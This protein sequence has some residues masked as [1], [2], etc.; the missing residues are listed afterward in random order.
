MLRPSITIV[1]TT[2]NRKENLHRALSS[3]KIQTAKPQVIVIDD[4]STDGTS[5]MVKKSFPDVLLHRDE[6]SK[7]YIVQRNLA[8]YLL[9]TQYLISIDD[10]AM[11]SSSSVVEQV[12]SE[13]SIPN[14]GAVAIPFIDVCQDPTVVHQV[15]LSSKGDFATSSYIG[16]AHALRRDVF[17]HLGGYREQLFHQGEESDYCL[18]MLES[19]YVVKLG[20]SDVIQ[21][22]ESPRRDFRRMDIY[23]RRNNILFGWH[24]VPTSLLPFYLLGT[25]ANGLLHGIRVGRVAVMMQGLAK[26]YRDIFS[27]C[28]HRSPV[29]LHTYRLYRDLVKRGPLTMDVV[30]QRLPKLAQA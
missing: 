23:G 13:F 29:S 25:T 9:Q 19:G 5:V 4:G 24:N 11:F 12:L 8:A 22:F 27:E 14:V 26:G 6:K 2:R 7:G 20:R 10:D 21:H 18:R 15:P 3:C 16:T 1:I 28:Q 30:Q 17:L